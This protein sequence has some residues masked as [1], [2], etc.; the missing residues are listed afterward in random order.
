MRGERM[1][2]KIDID[3]NKIDYEAINEEILRKVKEMDISEKYQIN[4]KIKNR[5][6]E[7]VNR[8]AK[9]YIDTT[10]SY[11]SGNEL[12][13]SAKSHITELAKE[14]IKE[15]ISVVVDDLFEKLPREKLDEMIAKLVPQIIVSMISDQLKNVMQNYY[16][17]AMG[18]MNQIAEEK[19]QNILNGRCY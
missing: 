2:I 9:D 10:W 3:M 11:N 1:E 4:E 17:G 6:S 14:E 7:A 19:I 16:Y 8:E 15:K 5:V 12:S 13:S 18:T